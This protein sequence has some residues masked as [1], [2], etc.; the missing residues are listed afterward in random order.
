MPGHFTELKQAMHAWAAIHSSTVDDLHHVYLD[1]DGIKKLDELVNL[2]R[3]NGEV[4]MKYFTVVRK[5]VADR[6]FELA[7]YFGIRARREN[8]M[9]ELLYEDD[10]G[11]DARPEYTRRYVLEEYTCK[12]CGKQAPPLKNECDV[13]FKERVERE[14]AELRSTLTGALASISTNVDAIT[15]KDVEYLEEISR[16]FIRARDA[17]T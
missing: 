17:P 3:C 7:N 11:Y 15:I 10:W 12:T 6:I 13:H 4:I 14:L 2:V 8:K 5:Q 1:A 16:K 9:V